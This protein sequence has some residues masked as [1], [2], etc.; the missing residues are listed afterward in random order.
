MDYKKHFKKI[1]AEKQ[2]KKLSKKYA[3][4]KIVIYGAGLYFSELQKHC[5]LSALN[6]IA[7]CDRKFS[8]KGIQDSTYKTI[9]PKE[10][11]NFDCD[12]ILT[13]V[14]ES[15]TIIDHLRYVILAGGSNYNIEIIPI[16]KNSFWSNLLSSLTK[17]HEN[18][19]KKLFEMYQTNTLQ[20]KFLQSIIQPEYLKPAGGEIREFQLKTFKFCHNMLKDFE[21]NDIKYFLTCGSLL[22]A[23]RHRGFVPWDDDFDIGMMREDYEKTK[24][25]CEKNFIKMDLST[26]SI[27]DK[28]LY[29]LWQ[30]Y[31]KEYPKQI[32]YSID[33]HHIQ[34]FRGK[35]IENYENIDIFCH[36]YY[37]ED[38]YEKEHSNYLQKINR[39][40]QILE[41][42]QLMY[43]FL[44][45]E[46]K[47]NP[48]IVQSSNKIY[49][50]I[51]DWL[52]YFFPMRGFFTKDMIFP[53]KQLEFEGELLYVPNDYHAYMSLQYPN[54]MEMPEDMRFLVHKLNRKKYIKN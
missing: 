37:A 53:L 1:N 47:N 13:A 51:D 28:N 7:L 19:E 26:V 20:L 43:D 15:E 8:N 46:M 23:I 5:D 10:L 49:Y 54:Y 50:S 35:S 34:I 42:Y 45:K 21:Q 44:Q 24:L 14:L 16:L 3:D 32:I 52:S 41:N 48:D 25:F 11:Y 22:G 9:S 12:I 18:K 17:K 29:P 31:F 33:Q 36:D 27:K 4:K 39:D 30:K 6:I 40:T 2:I 38:Y